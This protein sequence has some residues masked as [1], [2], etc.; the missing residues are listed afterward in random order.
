M[1]HYIEHMSNLGGFRVGSE[2]VVASKND[3]NHSEM[4]KVNTQVRI[5]L[6][7]ES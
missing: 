3:R 5:W 7:Y 4:Q 6:R 2:T 1:C